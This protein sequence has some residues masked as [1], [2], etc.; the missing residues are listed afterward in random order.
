MFL[1]ELL[2]TDFKN[3]GSLKLLFEKEMVAFCGKNGC[4]KTNVLD[5]IHILCMC[6][7][8]FSRHEQ[9]N[10]RHGADFYSIYGRLLLDK[11]PHK[12]AAM[13]HN[14]TGKAF[15]WDDE[16]YVKLADH[17][18]KMPIVFIAPGDV[19]LIYEGSELRRRWLD[20]LLSQS[21]KSYLFALSQYNRL[22]EQRNALLK[23]ANQSAYLNQLVLESLDAKIVE[24][25]NLI[26]RKRNTFMES[27]LSVFQQHHD[28]I[29][30]E[31]GVVNIS[32]QSDLHE[33]DLASLLKNN[34]SKDFELGRTE[35]G[36][37]K[38]DLVFEL[39]TY[40][41]KRY[42]SQG[43]IKSFLIALKLA[44]FDYLKEKTGRIPFLLLDDIFE[45]LDE[46]RLER[47]MQMVA[48]NHFGQIFISDTH[49]QRIESVF[50]RIKKA[51]QIISLDK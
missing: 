20:A 46:Y 12:I 31:A 45:K 39:N 36:L 35:K 27:Y 3:H 38:D 47:L 1:Q 9:R 19:A 37:H 16:L 13:Y 25:A 17:I 26:S 48:Q 21:D 22:L 49:K 29:S 33:D 10:I 8:Y 34:V 41:L 18:G 23:Q 5:A 42:G 11:Q 51:I 43:Q 28:F 7:S 14:Q 6:K 2:L 50:V 15:K 24:P 44:Q 40:P 30:N 4:G 32:Y